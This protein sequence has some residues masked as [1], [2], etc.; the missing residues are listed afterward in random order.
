MDTGNIIIHVLVNYMHQIVQKGIFRSDTSVM[1]ALPTH[2]NCYK[3]VSLLLGITECTCHEEEFEEG[4]KKR[5]SGLIQG[6][7][8]KGSVREICLKLYRYTGKKERNM[9]SRLAKLEQER[10]KLCDRRHDRCNYY[11]NAALVCYKKI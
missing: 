9:H 2:P 8:A 5:L 10:Q 3:G 4:D 6:P 7:C 1:C 11:G